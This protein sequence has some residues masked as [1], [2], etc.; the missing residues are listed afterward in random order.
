LNKIWDTAGQERFH[1]LASVFYK[2]F[3]LFK[4]AEISSWRTGSHA[5]IV[6]Y[7][8]TKKESFDGLKKWVEELEKNGPDNLGLGLKN[9]KFDIH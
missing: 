8:I 6:V 3:F 7:D 5:A 4:K 1:S 2:G 9:L